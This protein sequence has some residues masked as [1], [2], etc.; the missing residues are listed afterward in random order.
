MHQSLTGRRL[1]HGVAFFHVPAM[2]QISLISINELLTQL[3]NGQTAQKVRQAYEFANKIHNGRQRD[4]GELYIEHDLGVTQIVSQLSADPAALVASMLHDS[5]LPHT[6]QTFNTI[7]ETF[8]EEP[9]A[10]LE[11]LEHLYAYANEAQYQKH[12]D[13]EANRKTLEG[14]RRAVLAIIE[15]DIRVILIRMADC[16][17]DLRKAGTLS[18]E[19]RY[20][21]ANEAMN[22]YAPWQTD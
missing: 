3:P 17:Q 7:R 20:S 19:Q 2:T 1:Q 12:R 8:G 22:I 14:V 5:L 13:P 6:N 21:I 15:G 18:P 16:L 4:S 10:L 11:G 9:A